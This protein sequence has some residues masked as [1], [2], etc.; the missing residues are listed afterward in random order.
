MLLLGN[1]S[2]AWVLKWITDAALL[3]LLVLLVWVLVIMAG[4]YSPQ[5]SHGNQAVIHLELKLPTEIVKPSTDEVKVHNFESARSR[6]H[7][8]TEQVDWREAGRRF[9][10]TFVGFGVSLWILWNLRQI[11]ASLVA[12]K[13][14]TLANARRFRG[15]GLLLVF[16]AVYSPLEQTFS[17]LH[18]QTLFQ[19]LPQKGYFRLYADHLEPSVL[20][21]GLLIVLMA[22]VLRIGFEH[23]V[24]SE[25]VI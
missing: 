10:G 18:A 21:Y 13:P 19:L 24:D 3:G 9:L 14:L 17:Y 12:R 7:F 25:A 23:R 4:Q 5:G 15:I 1:R 2:L 20:F 8:R 6:I 22:E 11:L 16:R